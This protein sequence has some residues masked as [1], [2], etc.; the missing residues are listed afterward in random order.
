METAPVLHNFSKVSLG[1][2]KITYV[3]GGGGLVG[4]SRLTFMTPWTFVTP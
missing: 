1:K 4:K 2:F 3:V